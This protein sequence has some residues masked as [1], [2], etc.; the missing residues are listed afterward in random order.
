MKWRGLEPESK[1]TVVIGG[2]G[3][4]IALAFIFYVIAKLI[5]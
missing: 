4:I 2:T 5:S 1:A 3:I